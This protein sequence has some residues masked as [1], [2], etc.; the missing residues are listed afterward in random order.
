[1]DS[2]EKNGAVINSLEKIVSYVK[3]EGQTQLIKSIPKLVLV[4]QISAL[5]LEKGTRKGVNCLWCM[6]KPMSR[7]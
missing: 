1:M 2:L 4:K 6:L 3:Q 7:K 5:K